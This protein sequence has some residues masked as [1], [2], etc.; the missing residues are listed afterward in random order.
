MSSFSSS[1]PFPFFSM[2]SSRDSSR[3]D[4]NALPKP[5]DL[6]SVR[7][8]TG[9]R[10][11]WGGLAAALPDVVVGK[12]TIIVKRDSVFSQLCGGPIGK[13]SDKVCFE[14]ND[15]TV[16]SHQSKGVTLQA[17]IYVKAPATPTSERVIYKEPVGNLSLLELHSEMIMTHE[18]GDPGRW[19]LIL[20]TMGACKSPDEVRIQLGLSLIKPTRG[21][22]SAMGLSPDPVF[23][24]VK[25]EEDQVSIVDLSIPAKRNALK[26]EAYDI[27]DIIEE[28]DQ[29]VEGVLAPAN[30][31]TMVSKYQKVWDHA[32]EGSTVNFDDDK[33][34]LMQGVQTA[35]VMANKAGLMMKQLAGGVTVVGSDV[36]DYF[37][38]TDFKLETLTNSIGGLSEFQPMNKPPTSVWSAMA[39]L[40]AEVKEQKKELAINT[41]ELN[42]L[43]DEVNSVS[44]E[45][46]LMHNSVTRWSHSFADQLDQCSGYGKLAD[47]GSEQADQLKDWARLQF[48][49]WE[50]GQEERTECVNAVVMEQ[51][52]LVVK[53]QDQSRTA[54]KMGEVWLSS[55]QDITTA[56]N[57]LSLG[58]VPFSCFADNNIIFHKLWILISPQGTVEQNITA[59]SKAAAQDLS[60]D[61]ALVIHSHNYLL[62]PLF[63]NKKEKGVTE[64]GN[65]KKYTDF[66]CRSGGSGLADEIERNLSTVTDEIKSVIEQELP[67]RECA[68]WRILARELLQ[69]SETF[70]R[71]LIN[72]VDESYANFTGGGNSPADSWWIITHVI[73]NMYMRYFAPVRI[74]PHRV[75]YAGDNIRSGVFIWNAIQ[76]HFA[77]VA[78]EKR[79]MKD[80]PIVVGAFAEW[81]VHNSGRQEASQAKG[82]LVVIKEEMKNIRKS[83]NEVQ[84]KANSAKQTADK[85]FQKVSNSN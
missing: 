49:E 1:S 61:E 60:L 83:I 24:I 31:A 62:P 6:S 19:S 50:K 5:S 25:Q 11:S 54:Y 43:R 42:A 41:A 8:S 20:E 69:S 79:G 4:W 28:W 13:A 58:K 33:L 32:A 73:R 68:P 27:S 44:R 39:V 57:M 37:L 74:C 30:V 17:G 29:L 14:A 75:H 48:K 15:C 64:L 52:R 77:T 72:W 9:A 78:L 10:D 23:S 16:T 80:H 53:Q 38:S 85:A 59:S 7:P 2:S 67:G 46:G 82:D 71:N 66:R 55:A 84:T 34:E 70:I 21:I 36:D 56:A 40:Q 35:R 18:E 76:T 63:S 12:S 81:L 3:P 65:L 26:R 45:F 51:M 22:G 47:R